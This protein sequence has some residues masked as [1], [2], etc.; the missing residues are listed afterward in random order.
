MTRAYVDAGAR[1]FAPPC[2]F[3]HEQ[4]PLDWGHTLAAL[5][6]VRCNLFHDEKARSSENDQLVVGA[7]YDTLLAFCD[8]PYLPAGQVEKHVMRHWQNAHL[9]S[10]LIAA[11]RV[12]VIDGMAEQR[13][14]D[15]Q[16]LV[17]QRRRLEKLERHR[18]KLIDAYVAEAIPVADLKKRQEAVTVEQREAERLIQLASTNHDLIE[19][20]L[21]IALGLLEHCDRLYIGETEP[22]RRALNQAFYSALHVGPEGVIR[23]PLN[24]PFAQLRNLTIGFEDD[25]DESS[26]APQGSSDGDQFRRSQTTARRPRQAPRGAPRGR[27]KANP[28]TNK[29][30][31]GSNVL[32]LAERAGFEPARHLS[33]PTR[34]PVA[35]LRPLG[36]LSVRERPRRVTVRSARREAELVRRSSDTPRRE[37]NEEGGPRGTP[38]SER[39]DASSR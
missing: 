4:V 5:Y 3:E 36:H 22:F 32:I 23:A 26:D 11:V 12:T 16:L 19:E 34:F 17:T 1:E 21:E 6:R 24:P 18:Q 14:Q 15:K 20:R 37:P 39:S 8:L 10:E 7:A 29:G 33:A 27:T 31:R 2:Y 9:A 30:P 35:L 13:A 25:E 28:A 38:C